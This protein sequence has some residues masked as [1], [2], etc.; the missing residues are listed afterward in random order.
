MNLYPNDT[1]S[2][3]SDSVPPS[4]E[5]DPMV[6]V[7]STHERVTGCSP[8]ASAELGYE[9]DELIGKPART[10]FSEN[11]YAS[12]QHITRHVLDGECV[13]GHTAMFRRK[14]GLTVEMRLDLYPAH[15]PD[16]GI[17]GFSAAQ[18]TRTDLAP[19]LDSAIDRDKWIRAIVETAV[20]GIITFDHA[21]LIEYINPSAERMFG[22][23]DDEVVGRDIGLIMPLPDYQD[24]NHYYDQ[25]IR[26][27]GGIVQEVA[28]RRKTGETFPLEMS[29]SEV[30][31]GERRVFTCILHDITNRRKRQEEK[32]QLL[33]DL[34]KRNIELTCLYRAGEAMRSFEVLSDVFQ[35]VVRLIGPA[36]QYPDI[37]RCRLTLDGDRYVSSPF[38]ATPW[39]LGSD[40]IV[41][42]RKRGELEVFY[43]EERR[44][45]DGR[46]FLDEERELIEA[47]ASDIGF[48]V[49]RREAEAK[50]IQ[51]SKLASIGELA[52]GVG[53]EI[54]NP[55]NGIMNCADILAGEFE[56]DSKQHQFATLIR[57]EAE[58]IATIVRNLLRF[59]RQDREHHSPA[60]MCDIVEVVLSLSR[61]KIEKSHIRL[62]VDVPEDLP[63]VRCRSEQLQQVVMNLIINALQALDER[64]KG[65]NPDK[66]LSIAAEPIELSGAPFIRLTVEDHGCGIAP[67]HIERLFDPFFTTKG[68]DVGTG[69]GLSISNAIVKDHG[70]QITVTS[71]LGRYA[72]FHVDLPSESSPPDQEA[73][74]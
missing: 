62:E 63:R 9:P 33:R 41:A 32:D 69:L 12:W 30:T 56:E 43:L 73:S 17:T 57:S 35:G 64:Y 38:S 48:T 3:L 50:V 31:Q 42:G 8:A 71:E 67:T 53:H 1:S 28:G 18:S 68:R 44:G 25:N 6:L 55:L 11:E 70:G 60:R 36:F 16:G 15:G 58:R 49:E 14:D 27:T 5:R 65:M 21:G 2:P 20:D 51:A 26:E 46:I 52:A 54:N 24:H 29:I 23:T 72:R 4:T 37:A 40:I 47:L 61:K 19:L 7:F 45:S 10:L 39:R 13:M 59:A 34:N 66:I 74:A 22:Y